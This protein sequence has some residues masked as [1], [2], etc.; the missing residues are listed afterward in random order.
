MACRKRG[1]AAARNPMNCHFDIEN[2]TFVARRWSGTVAAHGIRSVSVPRAD[3]HSAARHDARH[4]KPNSENGGK[5]MI[6]TTFE[7]QMMNAAQEHYRIRHVRQKQR[8]IARTVAIIKK[9]WGE[10]PP[11]GFVECCDAITLLELALKDARLEQQAS[12]ANGY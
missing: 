3:T 10:G 11:M 7:Q 2:Q 1:T 4:A 9:L 12:Y 8:Q 5:A 6:E